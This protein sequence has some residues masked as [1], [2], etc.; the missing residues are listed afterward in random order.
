MSEAKLLEIPVRRSSRLVYDKCG[1]LV[2]GI[3][4][5]SYL[6]LVAVPHEPASQVLWST[7]HQGGIFE[8]QTR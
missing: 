1:C 3:L 5:M 8:W 2:E 6:S 7:Q 4:M